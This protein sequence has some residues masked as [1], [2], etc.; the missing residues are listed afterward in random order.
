[1][2][3]E[4]NLDINMQYKIFSDKIELAMKLTNNISIPALVLE[5]LINDNLIFNLEDLKQLFEHFGEVLYI[6]IKEKQSVILFKTFFS[7]CICKIVMENK[8]NYFEN[9]NNNFIIRWFD[10]KQDAHLIPYQVKEIFVKISTKNLMMMNENNNS[11]KFNINKINIGVKTDTILNFDN[12][13]NNMNIYP[14]SNQINTGN[15]MINPIINNNMI[16]VI[17]RMSNFNRNVLNY[18]N[19]INNI[20]G[21]Q[22][23]IIINDNLFMNS[24][25]INILNGYNN[26]INLNVFNN[27][28]NFEIMNS[29]DYF[30]NTNI[31]NNK[32]SINNLNN[33]IQKN[34]KNR[35]FNRNNL[36]VNNNYINNIKNINNNEDKF[37]GKYTCKFEI[38]LENDSEFQISRKVIG[39]KGI[40]MK[41][42]IDECQ[43]EGESESVKLR[44]RG[45]GSGYKEGPQQ[46]ECDEPLHLCISTKTREQINKACFLVN[47][48]L[49]KIH[50]EYKIFCKKYGKKPKC[51]KIARKIE[52]R[53]FNFKFNN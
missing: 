36:F 15:N 9:M 38:L 51:E 6:V 10:L 26:N 24:N 12:N 49:E 22:K 47:K 41:K 52:N 45:K 27:I 48:L 31:I 18:N 21:L 33:N 42:I 39:S 1:M 5:Y 32:G 40:N 29:H 17:P 28:N 44:L 50:E 37:S 23:P 46:K 43:L 11:N 20:N 53:N 19:S 3:R 7:A 8:E 2:E 13:I 4:S 34:Y 35:M 30:N 14:N 16:D 25:N